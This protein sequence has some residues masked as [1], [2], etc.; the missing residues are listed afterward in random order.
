MNQKFG[1]MYAKFLLIFFIW[2][3]IAFFFEIGY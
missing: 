3:F 2:T 1:D